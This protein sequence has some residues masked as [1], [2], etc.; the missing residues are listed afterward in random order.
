MTT[1]KS[2]ADQIN[3]QNIGK[4]IAAEKGLNGLIDTLKLTVFQEDTQLSAHHN[5]F[6]WYVCNLFHTE[7]NKLN[8]MLDNVTRTLSEDDY[9]AKMNEGIQENLEK[10]I[11][12]ISELLKQST[13]RYFHD[14]G[15]TWQPPNNKP[16]KTIEGGRFTL[17]AGNDNPQINHIHETLDELKKEHKNLVLVHTLISET[18]QCITRWAQENSTR[19]IIHNYNFTTEPTTTTHNKLLDPPPQEFI[20]FGTNDLTAELIADAQKAKI[21]IRHSQETE[22]K[23]DIE[24]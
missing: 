24:R 4:K 17:V 9:N 14:T 13:Q 23:T 20:I 3:Q 16:L 2:L 5:E 1:H 8:K 10:D 15:L 7:Q 21:S 19:E 11:N 6:L 22:I 12:A 18:D